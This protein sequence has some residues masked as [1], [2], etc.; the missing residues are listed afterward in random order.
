MRP[1]APEAFDAAMAALGP[2]ERRP[3][4]AVAV[5]GGPDSLALCLLADGW[6]RR[7][8]AKL[9][10]LTVDHRLR[11][12]SGEE[13][14]RVGQ[15]MAAC[16]LEH[17]ILTWEGPKPAAGVQE[18]ARNARY[19][20]LSSWCREHGVLHLLLAHHRD[21]QAETFLMRLCRAS[22]PEGLAAMAPVVET[23]SVRL[24][25][26]LLGVPAERLKALLRAFSQEWIDDPS[27]RDDRFLRVR[28]RR[29]LPSMPAQG[30]TA[31]VL[32]TLAGRQGMAR[33]A[34]DMRAAALAARVCRV[35]PAGYVYVDPAG[36]REASPELALR[37]LG[38]ALAA[39]GGRPRAPPIERV[40]TLY[41]DIVA[42]GGAPSHTLSGCRVLGSR[43]RLIVCREARA[44]P[45]PVPVDA[46]TSLVW[47]GR[48]RI[49]LSGGTLPEQEN[50]VL[51]PLGGDGWR[52][53]VRETPT[54][55]NSGLPPQVRSTLPAL[56]DG[57]GIR[58]VPHLGFCRP[59]CAGRGVA[60]GSIV[61]SP[62]NPLSGGGCFL[63][64]A[65][66]RII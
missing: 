19:G 32:A 45:A 43:G 61:F 8:Q 46:A 29:A 66:S 20:L 49:R 50:L 28:V 53:I 38:R 3:H 24:L 30:V 23:P 40:R 58:V 13:A 41:C 1:V 55:R 31:D 44:L 25:R 4:L 52:Q 27:N 33:S 54:L 11:A 9:T 15:W 18:A 12:D 64:Y 14:R 16:G 6:A 2:F 51:R 7:H 26:P 22:G 47:D 34:L 17:R 39:V 35:H 10:A 59:D 36:L 65:D 42:P 37:V 5:S 63:A 62:P 56:A 57:R 60:F 21:D 48:F